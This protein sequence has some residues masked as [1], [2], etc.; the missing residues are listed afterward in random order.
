MISSASKSCVVINWGSPEL[1]YLAA[2]LANKGLLKTY[3]R[4]YANQH[5][6]WEK[7]LASLPGF[8]NIYRR[9]FGRRV[10]PTGLNISNVREIG[11][12]DDFATSFLLNVKLPQNRFFYSFFEERLK[13]KIRAEAVN[14]TKETDILIGSYYMSESAFRNR[15]KLNILNYPIAHHHYAI[16]LLTEEK[17]LEP[18]FS[19]MFT[20]ND[21]PSYTNYSILDSEI[22]LADKILV[23]S[24][25][26]K[27]SFIAENIAIDKVNVIPFGVDVSLFTS[28]PINNK[29]TDQFN[30]IYVGQIG[31]RKGISYLLKAYTKFMG[32]GTQLT[33]V[34]KIVNNDKPLIPYRDNFTYIP[35][36]PRS[37]LPD[38]YQSADVFV[39]PTLLEGMGLVVL[40]AM[41]SGLPV[42]T[43]SNG[44]GDIVRDGIDGY[45]VPI[46]NV[47]AIEEK[48]E[49]FR[50]HPVEKY[51]MGLNARTRA[52]EFTW[53]LYQSRVVDYLTSLIC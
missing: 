23:G 37:Q 5:R 35:H 8:S 17:E 44:P 40:E 28:S 1:N 3:I 7:I 26:A 19:S 34:G 14:E 29:K 27:N 12:S 49:Y 52:M 43:T 53:E 45:I 36:V 16:K 30:V 41:A 50:T 33:L 48:L 10:L 13:E 4:P 32:S 6:L 46:R 11:V 22:E 42:I 2:G 24:T 18:S 38:I 31:Q 20:T 21:I 25:F 15:P 47:D 39:F 9:T 51:Q